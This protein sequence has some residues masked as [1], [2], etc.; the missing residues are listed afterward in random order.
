MNTFGDLEM[1]EPLPEGGFVRKLWFGETDAYRDHLLRL[2]LESR[3]REIDRGRFK[4]RNWP[5]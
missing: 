5:Y 2:D 1:H 4:R 3:Q